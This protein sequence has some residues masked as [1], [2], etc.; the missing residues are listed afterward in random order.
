VLHRL[1]ETSATEIDS[2]NTSLKIANQAKSDFLASM[3]HE[4]RTPLHAIIS[5]AQL[6]LKRAE[7]TNREKIKRYFGTINDSADRLLFLLNDILDLAKLEA[8]KMT[9]DITKNNLYEVVRELICEQELKLQEKNLSIFW[10]E[11]ATTSKAEFDKFRIGQV[12]SNILSN[13]IKFSPQGGE[14]CFRITEDF[15]ATGE[16]NIPIRGLCFSLSDRGKGV[17]EHELESIFD[18]FVQSHGQKAELGGTGLGLTICKEIID[19]H[20]G[21]IWAE[22]ESKQ[23]ATF[24]FIIPIEHQHSDV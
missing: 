6:G 3:S 24:S 4:L 17:K 14:L 20:Q 12:I 5:F 1:V 13:A 16:A 19:A 7:G 11:K 18:K 2:V 9:L 23:G 21:K 8:G 10:Q 22:S 15:L